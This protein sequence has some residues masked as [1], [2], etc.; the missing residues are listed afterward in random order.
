MAPDME[1]L[2]A[3]LAVPL[4][5]PD[6]AMAPPGESLGPMRSSSA[7]SKWLVLLT[8]R[9][10]R[11][12]VSQPKAMAATATSTATPKKRRSH[13][14]AAKERFIAAITRVLAAAAT[15]S[16]VAAPSA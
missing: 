3:P 6:I 2:I 5:A 7:C 16:E 10:V 4:I 9:R 14:P 11:M 12:P 15:A 1:P 8:D 13:S